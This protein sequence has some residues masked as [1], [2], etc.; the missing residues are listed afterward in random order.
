MDPAAKSQESGKSAW[1]SS[2][3]LADVAGALRGMKRVVVLSHVKPDGDAIGSL[4]ALSRSLM[5]AG[6]QVEMWVV[7]PLPRWLGQMMAGGASVMMRELSPG[8][9]LTPVAGSGGLMQQPDA[10]VVVDTGS[11]SQV[12]ECKPALAG[13]ASKTFIVDHHLQGDAE[14][15]TRRVVDTTCAS[16]TQVLAPLC[17]ML[18]GVEGGSPAKLPLEV[19]EP[20]YLGLATD[21]GWLRYSSVTPATLRLAADLIECGVDHTRLYKMIEQQ[22][23]PGRFRLLAKA[24]ASLELHSVHGKDDTA[25]MTLSLADFHAAGADAG[26]TGGFADMVLAI[27]TVEV[28]AVLTEHPV[29]AGEPA[30]TKF[31]LRSKPGPSAV[32]VNRVC[33]KIGGGGHARAA[34]AKFAAPLGESK[35]KLLEALK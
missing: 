33:Q 19:A 24:L 27:A 9:P 17:A 14:I 21:T 34:G 10:Y 25:V 30:L 1:V 23:V 35:K 15:A 5:R 32:D 4:L 18:C 29:K 3:T 11:W 2:T 6:V 13:Q 26:D 12:A 16:C 28:A 20:L 31:S 22:D 7:G 8:Q